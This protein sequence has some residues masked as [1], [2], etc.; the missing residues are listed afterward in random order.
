MAYENFKDLPKTFNI[1]K[2]MKYD[3]YQRDVTS[4]AYRY[5]DKKS[6]GANTS[7]GAVTSA[8]SETL[9]TRDKSAIMQNQ[10]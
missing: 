6:S 4:V 9:A 7:G 1:A 10:Q 2:R 5:F 3:G 8:R